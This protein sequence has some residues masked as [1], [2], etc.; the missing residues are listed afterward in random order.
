ML[1]RLRTLA[2]EIEDDFLSPLSER[3]RV[4]L[5]GLLLQLAEK[6]EPRCAQL[7]APPKS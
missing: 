5:H 7:A 3:E 2:A 1:R 4:T 6:H